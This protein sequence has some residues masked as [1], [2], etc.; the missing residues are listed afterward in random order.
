MRYLVGRDPEAHK[1]TL[2]NAAKDISYV[3]QMAHDAGSYA[4]GSCWKN[5]WDRHSV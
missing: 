2:T 5:E 4:G 1:F 3:N